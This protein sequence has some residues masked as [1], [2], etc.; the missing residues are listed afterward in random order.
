[1]NHAKTTPF[2]GDANSASIMADASREKDN[3][4]V[5]VMAETNHTAIE[6]VG[7]IRQMSPRLYF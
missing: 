4:I 6:A 5:S 3:A 1:M 7:N 2:M